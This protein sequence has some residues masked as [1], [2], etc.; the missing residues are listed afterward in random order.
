MVDSVGGV[1]A[2]EADALQANPGGLDARS[3]ELF[4]GT[5]RTD[6]GLMVH[7]DPQRLMPSHLAASEMFGRSKQGRQGE[8]R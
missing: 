8:D 4:D 1:V 5:L 2:M 7:L 3:Q 6:S